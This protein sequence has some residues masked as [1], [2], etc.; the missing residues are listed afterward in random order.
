MGI[1]KKLRPLKRIVGKGN[2]KLAEKLAV[3]KVKLTRQQV[4]KEIKINLN[5]GEIDPAELFTFDSREEGNTASKAIF[6]LGFIGLRNDPIGFITVSFVPKG[7][8]IYTPYIIF[9]QTYDD[10]L[11]F[12]S[13]ESWGKY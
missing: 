7:K 5:K 1:I 11:T 8:V 3:K 2:I 10:Y 12:L 9:Q 6:R 4:L 13:Q